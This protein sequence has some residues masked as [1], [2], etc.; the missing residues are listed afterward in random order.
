[1]TWL[2]NDLDIARA[3]RMAQYDSQYRGC[4]HFNKSV[5]D[6]IA[7]NRYGRIKNCRGCRVCPNCDGMRRWLNRHITKRRDHVGV[8]DTYIC[9]MCGA[10]YEE[11]Y[12]ISS[13]P[14]QQ[15]KN[16]GQCE[17]QNC[18]NHAYEGHQHT[19]LTNGVHRTF[20]ICLTHHRRLKTWRHHPEK[21]EQHIPIVVENGVLMDNPHY[22]KKQERRG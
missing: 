14:K 2:P 3:R 11:H 5:D 13:T 16:P 12:V 9:A 22:I 19:A 6:H 15:I 18:R 20:I 8:C 17:V 21:T 4:R 7:C 1:M 10:Y